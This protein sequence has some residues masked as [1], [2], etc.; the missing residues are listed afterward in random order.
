[1]V[2]QGVDRLMHQVKNDQMTFRR[3]W[4]ANSNYLSVSVSVSQVQN[5]N[6]MDFSQ[7]SFEGGRGHKKEAC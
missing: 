6:P 7:E 1:M 2:T 3:V 4:V 5:Q